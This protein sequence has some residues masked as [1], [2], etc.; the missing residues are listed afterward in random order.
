MAFSEGEIC[1]IC[2]SVNIRMFAL[3]ET[4]L[5]NLYKTLTNSFLDEIEGPIIVCFTCHA[6]LIRCR[7]LQQQAI[8]S[9]VVLEQ[10]LSGGSMVLSIPSIKTYKSPLLNIGLTHRLLHRRDFAKFATLGK[11]ATIVYISW[12][13]YQEDAAALPLFLFPSVASYDT[14]PMDRYIG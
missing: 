8:E 2:L 14:H 1:R 12:S 3:K 9:N 11:L 10:L 13:H 7:R 6:R 5:Q 4:G